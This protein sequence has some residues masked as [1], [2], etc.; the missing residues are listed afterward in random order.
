MSVFKMICR[1]KMMP[2]FYIAVSSWATTKGQHVAWN[3]FCF[4]VT[5]ITKWD[6]T[7]WLLRTLINVYLNSQ[8]NSSQ[9]A[10]TFGPD[11]SKN[12]P[13]ITNWSC[14]STVRL[15]GVIRQ[16]WYKKKSHY[17]NS[18]LFSR[19]PGAQSP[20]CAPAEIICAFIVKRSRMLNHLNDCLLHYS[21][22][23]GSII[24]FDTWLHTS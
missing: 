4:V 21:T 2:Y 10:L 8:Q 18:F 5:H 1:L 13:E 20:K 12:V 24:C 7:I 17:L 19:V 3:A 14:W 23:H 15:R 22:F 16:W 6:I 9:G 11:W